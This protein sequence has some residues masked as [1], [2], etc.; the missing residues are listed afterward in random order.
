V[1]A[2]ELL[3]ETPK[4]ESVDPAAN[5]A[6]GDEA[7][8]QQQG[9]QPTQQGQ[10][11]Q[12][13]P[14]PPVNEDEIQPV[15]NGNVGPQQEETQPQETQPQETQQQEH[16]TN[17][18]DPQPDDIDP[19]LDDV[20]PYQIA[21]EITAT[22]I[23]P[24]DVDIADLVQV[25]YLDTMYFEDGSEM[26]VALFHTPDGE[27]YLMVD[28]DNDLTFDLVTDLEFNPLVAVDGNM[29][30]SDIEDMMD[31]TGD[32][33][34]YN[35]EQDELE[36]MHGENPEADIVNTEDGYLA[37]ADREADEEEIDQSIWDE[38]DD[39]DEDPEAEEDDEL[40]AD[41]GDLDADDVEID[42]I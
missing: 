19:M 26:P 40:L 15:D 24:N 2:S 17:D 3:K 31:E 14:Q 36:L 42:E 35:P 22:E 38:N 41:A 34:A 27:E 4:E 5:T 20:D 21:Q 10:S 9:T 6:G 30:L 37:M 32:V 23:D 33:L 29:T 18:I 1:A 16:A 8:N 7:T 39:E 28:I 11:E 12:Q 13:T 25:D